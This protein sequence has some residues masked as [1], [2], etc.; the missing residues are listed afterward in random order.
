TRD[1]RNFLQSH[2]RIPAR[3]FI[4]PDAVAPADFLYA[5]AFAFDHHQK[6]GSFPETVPLANNVE[7][8]PA[9][10]IAKD[11][12]DLFGGWTIHRAGFRAPKILE[13]ARLQAW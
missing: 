3:V 2:H 4:G 6:N 11:T 10:H 12:P 5:L 9:R 7:L 13:V 8:L 1:V